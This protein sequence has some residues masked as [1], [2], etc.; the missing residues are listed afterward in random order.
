[1]LCRDV[2]AALV[3]S[4]RIRARGV[5]FSPVDLGCREIGAAEERAAPRQEGEEDDRGETP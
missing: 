3:D 2:A 5:R 1:V 4:E